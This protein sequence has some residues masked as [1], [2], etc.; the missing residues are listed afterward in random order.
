[1]QRRA[2]ALRPENTGRK[3][4]CGASW[5]RC[6]GASHPAYRCSAA[7]GPRRRSQRAGWRAL[8][9]SQAESRGRPVHVHKCPAG[10]VSRPPDLEERGAG[11]LGGPKTLN[12]DERSLTHL[13][14][15]APVQTGL[16]PGRHGHRRNCK[17]G[18]PIHACCIQISSTFY[19]KPTTQPWDVVQ[20]HLERR[21][22]SG[23]PQI[24]RKDVSHTTQGRLSTHIDAAMLVIEECVTS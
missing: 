3:R 6:P 11:S 14:T 13:G 19:K 17:N 2:R 15:P 21:S 16:M 20:G 7:A 8:W 4:A 23:K 12:H 5:M 24:S 9:W 1:M 10:H 22:V 18:G